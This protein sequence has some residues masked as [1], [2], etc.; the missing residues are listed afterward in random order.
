MSEQQQ[1][2]KTH[3]PVWK[4]RIVTPIGRLAF[5]HISAPDTIGQYATGKYGATI[6][7]PKSAD[8]S[9]LRDAVLE[10]A[11]VAHGIAGSPEDALRRVTHPFRD[12][13]LK[14]GQDGFAGC[15]YLRAKS[16]S[17]PVCKGPDRLD[18]SPERF[19]NGCRIRLSLDAMSYVSTERVRNTRGEVETVKMP[20]VTF[21]LGA[22][23]FVGDGERLR[24]GGGGSTGAE[25]GAVEDAGAA[26][27]SAD[28][29]FR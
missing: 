29:L 3:K 8:I 28:S 16:K 15:L 10:L 11:K 25:F 2:D 24:G 4:N 7:I 19:Y 9:A 6:L 26:G 5:G 18:C 22:A 14:V 13:D 20:G 23:Q 12:G 1:N 27:D 21:L 17:P